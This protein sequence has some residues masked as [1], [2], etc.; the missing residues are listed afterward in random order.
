MNSFSHTD[1][2]KAA[3]GITGQPR[4]AVVSSMSYLIRAALIVGMGAAVYFWLT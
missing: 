3:E 2:T 1:R 4:P